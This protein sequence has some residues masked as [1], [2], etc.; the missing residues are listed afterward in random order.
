MPT[1]GSFKGQAFETYHMNVHHKPDHGIALI[2]QHMNPRKC[3]CSSHDINDEWHC[4]F[5]R[6]SFLS[7][8]TFTCST[9][10]WGGWSNVS[11]LKIEPC[12]NDLPGTTTT[13]C[14]QNSFFLS[15]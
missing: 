13:L 8:A 15:F 3:N 6:G 1:Y 4:F 7:F 2:A 14:A 10:A 5:K 11:D 12:W 9:L